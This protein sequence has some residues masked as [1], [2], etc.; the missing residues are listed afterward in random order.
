MKSYK[1]ILL[2]IIF[3]LPMISISC[4]DESDLIIPKVDTTEPTG[5]EGTGGEDVDRD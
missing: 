4:S 2:A 1:K 3:V 5:A